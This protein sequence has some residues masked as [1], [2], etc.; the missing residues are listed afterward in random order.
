MRRGGAGALAAA[1]ALALLVLVSG[2][3]RDPVLGVGTTRLAVEDR[4]PAPA[5]AGTTLEGGRLDLADLA[6]RVVVL[7]NWASWCAPCRAEV[8]VLVD[9]ARQRGGEVAFVGLNVSDEQAAAQAFV[10]ETGMD[11][12]S[13]VDPNGALLATI[14][15]VPA[16]SLPSTIV[17][18]PQGRVAARVIGEVTAEGLASILDEITVQG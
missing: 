14:P 16:K 4:E 18:D 11:Y 10:T 12:P 15:G 1:L 13:I 5:I 3:G 9:A 7:N 6:G 8:P 17:I 2:C